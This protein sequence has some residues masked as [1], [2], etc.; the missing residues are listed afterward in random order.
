M[1]WEDGVLSLLTMLA[2]TKVVLRVMV[3]L[4]GPLTEVATSIH[5]QKLLH[6]D[7]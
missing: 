1:I 4:F 7:A 2:N 5:W 3:R 6:R